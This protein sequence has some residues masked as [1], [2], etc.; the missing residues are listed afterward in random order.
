[1]FLSCSKMNVRGKYTIIEHYLSEAEKQM[2]PYRKGSTISCIDIQGKLVILNVTENKLSWS[3][4]WS[5]SWDQE[6]DCWQADKHIKNQYRDV[7]LESKH[8]VLGLAL[9]NMVSTGFLTITLY[10]Y[11]Y[12]YGYTRRFFYDPEGNF[13]TNDSQHVYDSL[14]ID[15]HTYFDVAVNDGF[16][17]NKKHG[18]LQIK[19]KENNILFKLIP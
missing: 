14:Q 3:E 19:D 12:H 1:M 17:Y 2:I 5:N 6:H 9:N 8:S 4:S 16:Y 18:V 15:N 13:T 11:G 10:P 7:F